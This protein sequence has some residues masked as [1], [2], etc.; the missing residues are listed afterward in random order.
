M[1]II[2]IERSEQMH[3]NTSTHHLIDRYH[4]QIRGCECARHKTTNS[5]YIATNC[6]NNSRKNCNNLD[7]NK[8]AV[9][10]ETNS[11]TNRLEYNM[12]YVL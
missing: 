11:I 7:V 1:K 4:H 9:I 6:T 3:T 8:I 2:L 12:R 10:I 5:L